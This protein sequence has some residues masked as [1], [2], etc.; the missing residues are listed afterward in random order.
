MIKTDYEALK[1]GTKSLADLKSYFW[2]G[3]RD[4]Y[5]LGLEGGKKLC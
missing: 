2:N 1:N 4:R 3:Y 5:V